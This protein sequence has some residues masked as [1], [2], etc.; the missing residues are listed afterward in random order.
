[1]K[2]KL[3]I[4]LVADEYT[5]KIIKTARDLGATG[6]TVIKSAR[7]EGLTPAKTF[8]GLTM[9]GQVDVV[10]F[11]VEQHMSREILEAIAET[12]QFGIKKGTGVALQLDVEDAVGL[13]SQLLK[14]QEE[15]GEKL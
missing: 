10:L 4:A 9:E 3:I 11:I 13:G 14:I 7:G 5:E 12:G 1:M 2:F 15:I 8:L 6:A